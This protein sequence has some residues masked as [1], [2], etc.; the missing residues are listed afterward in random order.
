M[1]IEL[2]Q[3]NGINQLRLCIG[4]VACVQLTEGAQALLQAE[5]K[6]TATQLSNMI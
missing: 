2:P 1:S 5:A 6:S 4:H 3:Q